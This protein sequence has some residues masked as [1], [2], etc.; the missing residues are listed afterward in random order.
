MVDA[1]P[2]PR[3]AIIDKESIPQYAILSH[4]W[5][6]GEVQFSDIDQPHAR[7]MPGYSKLTKTGIAI[8]WIDTCCI[9]KSNSSEL[10][11]AINSM[12]MWYKKAQICYA[13][14]YDV[15]RCDTLIAEFSNSQWFRRGWTLQELVAPNNVVFFSR[16]WQEIGSKSSFAR[17]IEQ[18]TEIDRGVLLTNYQEEVSVAKKVSWAT[19]RQTMRVEDRAYSLLEGENAF[20]RL[21]IEIMK[22]SNDQSNFAWE[23]HRG[24]TSASAAQC[25]QWSR[26]R[27]IVDA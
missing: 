19:G 12:F 5:R 16:D 21:Q 2:Q 1:S 4:R 8:V 24:D 23:S 7:N 14:L 10:S 17:L 13:Y 3:S 20:V 11:D 22:S 15:S 27:A 25:R 26:A 9:N 6:D 18:I